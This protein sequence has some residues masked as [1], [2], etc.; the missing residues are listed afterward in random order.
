MRAVVAALLTVKPLERAEQEVAE[1][2]VLMD[3]L[4]AHLA[5]QILVV[6]REEID[7]AQ[8]QLQMAV[9]A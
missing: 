4:T 7:L 3:R 9:L 8:E 2:V 5:A 1:M 6:A